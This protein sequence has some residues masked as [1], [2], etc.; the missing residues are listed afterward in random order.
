M[1]WGNTD[2]AQDVDTSSQELLAVNLG[3]IS[4]EDCETEYGV[5]GAKSGERMGTRSSSEWKVYDNMMCTYTEGQDACQVR[6]L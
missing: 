1:G 6:C 2:K 4:N 5:N 3:V